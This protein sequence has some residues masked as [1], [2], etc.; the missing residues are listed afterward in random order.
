MSPMPK[1][2][3]DHRS[4]TTSLTLVLTS[5]HFNQSLD[6]NDGQVLVSPFIH[7]PDRERSAHPLYYR[8][9]DWCKLRLT[10][11]QYEEIIDLIVM[12]KIFPLR[13][14][15][16]FTDNQLHYRI[17]YYPSSIHRP[18]NHK[19]F[20][21]LSHITLHHSRLHITNFWSGQLLGTSLSFWS[22]A[23]Y[24][25]SFKW[26]V[27][28]TFSLTISYLSRT[29]N[30]NSPCFTYTLPINSLSWMRTVLP[31]Y[32]LTTDYLVSVQTGQWLLPDVFCMITFPSRSQTSVMTTLQKK[33]SFF[34]I[35]W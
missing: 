9:E 7:I 11:S 30:G 26:S 1:W 18:L 2:C 12:F 33:H 15:N 29:F 28:W 27:N 17:T 13:I 6:V 32:S 23:L 16:T 34:L 4:V 21:S 8:L 14:C 5:L 22:F 35:I 20:E 19:L 31:P 10:Y 3:K 24:H 25:K